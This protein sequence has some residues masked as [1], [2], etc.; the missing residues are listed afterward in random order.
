MQNNGNRDFNAT[1]PILE[2]GSYTVRYY[3]WDTLNNFNGTETRAFSVDTTLPVISFVS[4]TPANN[5]FQTANAIPIN[6]SSS[7]ANTHY[8]FT[9]FNRDLLLWMRMDDVNASG[10]PTDLSTYCY[11]A[12]TEILT[13]EGWKLFAELDENDEV[14]T[15]NQETGKREWQKPSERQ[16]FE[17]EGACIGLH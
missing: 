3:C 12:R 7:D 17:H 15:L 6:V 10:D 13:G 5:S 2:D 1:D 16:E 14:M 11:D 8:A 4:P 9:D